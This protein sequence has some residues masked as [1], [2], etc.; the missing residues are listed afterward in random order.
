MAEKEFEAD[1]P[2]GLV[3][4]G[5]PEGEP[6]LMAECLVEEYVRLGM[7]DAQLLAIF[8]N[9]FFAGAH[10]LYRSRGE[11]RLKAVIERARTQWG[12]PRFVVTEAG[13]PD[14]A[15]TDTEVDSAPTEA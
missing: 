10:A 12:Q 6:D 9:P 15:P 14:V 5:V 11:E 2:M 1:D 8:K 3:G 4:I 13:G 7:S